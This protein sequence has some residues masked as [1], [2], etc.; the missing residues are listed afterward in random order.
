MYREMDTRHKK[1][2]QI[3]KFG[4]GKISEDILK[5]GAAFPA[6]WFCAPKIGKSPSER[7]N[8]LFLE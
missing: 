7:E 3:A 1:N 5:K 6:N 2:L 8:I 4:K